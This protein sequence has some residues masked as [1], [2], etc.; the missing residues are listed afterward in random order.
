MP[1]DSNPL[2]VQ[3]RLVCTAGRYILQTMTTLTTM[4]ANELSIVTT[5]VDAALEF[6]RG[7]R[8][9]GILLL[10]AAALSSRFPGFGTLVSIFLRLVRWFK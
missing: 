3:G 8:R 9:N 1:V 10:A 6:A 2:P 7:R 5:L 4:G